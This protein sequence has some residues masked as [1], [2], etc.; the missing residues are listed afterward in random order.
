MGSIAAQLD[1]SDYLEGRKRSS[2]NMVVPLKISSPEEVALKVGL[3]AKRLRLEANMTQ[4]ELALR[5][6]IPLPTLR[7]FENTGLAP[8]LTVVRLAQVL[9]RD[10][11]LEDLFAPAEVLPDSADDLIDQESPQPRQRASRKR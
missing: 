1:V 9:S 4:D 3:A 6:G 5:S 11:R 10:D 8:F 7:K 2:E